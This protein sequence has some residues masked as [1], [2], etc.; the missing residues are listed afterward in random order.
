M[1]AN[2]R[3]TVAVTLAEMTHHTAPRGPM[4]ARVGEEVE[5]ATHD[6]LRAQKSPPPWERPGCHSD[7]RPQRSDRTSRHSAG[8]SLLL[9]MPAL[10]GDDGVDG[11]SSS[12]TCRRRKKQEEEKREEECQR[13]AELSLLLAVP[14]ERRSAEQRARIMALVKAKRKRKKRRT[15]KV[16]KSSSSRFSCGVRIRRCGLGV[17]FL[18]VLCPCDHAA[19]VPAVQ[20]VCDHDGVSDSVHLQSVGQSCYATETG[21]HSAQ[22]C[23]LLET[24]QVQCLGKVVDAPVVVQPPVPDGPDSARQRR[25]WYA[26]GSF[27]WL[28]ASLAVFPSFVGKTV[29]PRMY[30]AVFASA[31]EAYGRIQVFSM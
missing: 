2:E 18:S 26:H 15:R 4:M 29:M 13:E 19:P 5:N 12:R 8:K 25:Q 6:G 31:T 21:T 24:P 11:T 9:V 22:L 14:Y 7:P 27:C 16:L 10:R 3:M 30:L 20:G 28:F 1:A 17:R 23:R